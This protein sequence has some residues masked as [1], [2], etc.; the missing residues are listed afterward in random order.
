[1]PTAAVRRLERLEQAAARQAEPQAN[2][3]A[4]AIL[5][6]LRT[7]PTCSS[8][9]QTASAL[10]GL[11]RLTVTGNAW[12]PVEPTRRQIEFL[13]CLGQ[14]AFYGGAAGGGKSS[15][16]L[17]AA[18]MFADVPGYAALLLRR[19]YSDLALPGALMH[20]AH[21][22]L[23][24][25]QARWLG[26]EHRWLFPSGASLSFGYL[27]NENDKY[28]YQSAEFQ[29]VGFDE[30]TQFSES[31]FT[32]L[33]SRLR[34]LADVPLSLRIRSASNPGGVRHL[35]AKE[36]YLA[37]EGSRGFVPARLD[38][39]PHLDRAEYVASL[40]QLDPVTR[41]RLLAGD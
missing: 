31:Q 13:L 4:E 15:A 34:R 20:R 36:R 23:G 39:N 9:P 17:A 29:V 26:A 30:L 33:F 32:Y 1:M 21:E 18:L 35:W 22:W 6:A 41:A 28:R 16:L 7:L 27:E 38:D 3:Q 14:E 5:S 24:G 12:V 37:G 10:R 19:R 11:Y 40:A 2:P 25:T 8:R